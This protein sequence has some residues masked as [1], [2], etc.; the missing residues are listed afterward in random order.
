MCV[1]DLFF[2]FYDCNS[3]NTSF[4]AACSQKKVSASR[5]LTLKVWPPSPLPRLTTSF[6]SS[7]TQCDPISFDLDHVAESGERDAGEGQGAKEG[8]EK[9]RSG[10]ETS[11]SSA[12]R[13]VRKGPS[14]MCRSSNANKH[15][16]L[17]YVSQS[18]PFE[19]R[20]GQ[21]VNMDVL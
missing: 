10:R 16:R 14:G 18:H 6:P 1:L 17:R 9:S 3:F 12:V 13:F 19:L 7:Q 4:P 8:G 15:T 11:S 21:A 20:G 2:F 5:L